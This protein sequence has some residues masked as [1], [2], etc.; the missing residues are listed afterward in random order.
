[1]DIPCKIAIIGGTGTVGRYIATHAIKKGYHVRML[2]R[3][4]DKLLYKNA[5]IGLVK[6]QVQDIENIQELLKDCQVVINTFGQ[7]PKEEPIYSKVTT[8]IF[9]VMKELNIN[10]YIGVS[11]GS[12]TIKEDK[13]SMMNRFGAKIF[14]VFFSKMMQDKK[15]EWEFLL[16]NKHIKWTLIRLPFVKDSLTS[17]QIKEN[18]TD[19]PG[20]K[21]TNQDIATF[22]IDH[23]DNT[24]YVHKAPFISH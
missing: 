12:L 4:P 18:L 14:E 21:I 8:N 16:N 23:I 5:K 20:T 6:G 3:N 11:G 1:M 2:V 7:P 19:M 24:K 22:I 9:K 13:K 10:R 15:L 17:K